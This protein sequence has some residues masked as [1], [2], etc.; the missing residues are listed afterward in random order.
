MR[1]SSSSSTSRISAAGFIHL[2]ILSE[3]LEYL[4]G[5]LPVTPIFEREAAA[6]IANTINKE[7]Q[8]GAVR[9]EGGLP[10]RMSDRFPD[11]AGRFR[12][13]LHSVYWIRSAPKASKLEEV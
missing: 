10:L 3:C 7:N 4:Y 6:V 12:A 5:V 8:T 2:R 11:R 9:C 13:W 1:S